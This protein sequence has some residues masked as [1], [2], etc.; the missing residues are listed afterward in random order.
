MP[1]LLLFF[2]ADAPPPG[3]ARR[4]AAATTPSALLSLAFAARF[5]RGSM[6]LFSPADMRFARRFFRRFDACR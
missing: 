1:L 3:Y 6:P 5:R 4:F 2:A